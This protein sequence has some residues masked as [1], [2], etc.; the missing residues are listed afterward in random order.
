M[1]T[2]ERSP[3][4]PAFSL[5]KAVLWTKQLYADAKRNLVP[6]DAVAKA[7]GSAAERGVS[8]P[9]RQ[10]VATMRQYGL[11][12]LGGHGQYRI[13]PIGFDLAIHH[14]EDIEYELALKQAALAPAIF[15]EL[16]SK[17]S[18][19]PNDH[20]LRIVLMKEKAFSEDGA[21][22]FLK[23]F[24]DTLAYSK[25]DQGSYDGGKQDSDFEPP[26]VEGRPHT[27][28]T[29]TPDARAMRKGLNQ[30]GFSMAYTWPLPNGT[31]V[32]VSFQQR[33]TTKEL[34]RLIA[35]LNMMKDDL[36]PPQPNPLV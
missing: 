20:I 18:E 35:Y 26:A 22:K 33:P 4:Y 29:Q 24:R 1:A 23:A 9:A 28:G 11:I 8:G 31:D 3:N 13:S 12:E 16:S 2:Q 6:I 32:Q 30:E 14:P 7:T 36:E 15:E 10:K 27:T 17:Y 21:R 5:E 25:L 34:E 19:L